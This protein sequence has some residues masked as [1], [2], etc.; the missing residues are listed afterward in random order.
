MHHINR[1]IY[2][3]GGIA[4]LSPSVGIGLVSPSSSI[5]ISM[6]NRAIGTPG[7][8]DGTNQTPDKCDLCKSRNRHYILYYKCSFC[9]QWL[10]LSCTFKGYYVLIC[11]HHKVE[12]VEAKEFKKQYMEHY[13]V[14]SLICSENFKEEIGYQRYDML[15]E[16]KEKL[17]KRCNF[18][19]NYVSYFNQIRF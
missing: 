17:K 12:I 7:Y 1:H 10:C 19:V 18:L 4:L 14:C 5:D 2:S 15:V 9:K 13:L 3:S 6:A 11:L 8:H 16:K